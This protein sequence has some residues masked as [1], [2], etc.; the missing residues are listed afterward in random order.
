MIRNRTVRRGL[1]VALVVI[2]GLLMWAAA[3]PI[4]GGILFVAA[5]ALEAIGIRLEHRDDGS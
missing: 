5:I 1:G 2:G 3:S 4:A